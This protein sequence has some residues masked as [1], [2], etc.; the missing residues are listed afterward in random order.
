MRK[1]S[2]ERQPL[3]LARVAEIREPGAALVI[4]SCELHIVQDDPPVGRV[5]LGL[6]GQTREQVG[7]MDRARRTRRM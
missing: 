4:P 6:G 5:R 2:R 7:L 3:T 1:M